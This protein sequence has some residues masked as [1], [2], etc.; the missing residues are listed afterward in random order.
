MM[1][2]LKMVL[3]KVMVNILIKLVMFIKDNSKEMFFM[4]KVN[5]LGQM[6]IV[7]K[8][9]SLMGGLVKVKC[10]IVMVFRVREI[11]MI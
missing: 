11:L 9:N 6:V 7:L 2:S 4:D 1:E 10:I 8:V 5:I 3:E